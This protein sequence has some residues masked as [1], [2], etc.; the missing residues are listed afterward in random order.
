[1]RL[2]KEV[3]ST[4]VS[5]KMVGGIDEICV[6]CLRDQSQWDCRAVKSEAR[7]RSN[8]VLSIMVH[9]LVQDNWYTLYIFR[10]IASMVHANVTGEIY[11]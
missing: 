1:V 7:F 8:D 11:V 2:T 4:L 9:L 5:G 6:T 3:C 10:D